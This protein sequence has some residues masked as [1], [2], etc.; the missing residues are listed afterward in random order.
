MAIKLFR[1]V[2]RAELRDITLHGIRVNDF[3]YATTKLFASSEADASEYG[4]NNYY[5]DNEVNFI[6]RVE[7]P[8]AVYKECTL[9]I[10]DGMQTVAIPAELL[11][12]VKF[13][14]QI[15]HSKKPSNPFNK[16]L[17]SLLITITGLLK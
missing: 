16:N 8:D 15:Q 13:E 3:G 2:S 11:R 17:W 5:L 6:I 14:R 10:A 12:E 1:A 7:V 9:L 4:R